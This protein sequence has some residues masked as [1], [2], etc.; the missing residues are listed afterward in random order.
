MRED[1]NALKIIGIVADVITISGITILTV[2]SS[3]RKNKDL[4]G[5][6]INLYLT[7]FIR[8]VLIVVFVGIILLYIQKPYNFFL[9]V[10]KGYANG[11]LWEK[12]KEIQH[13]IAYFITTVLVLSVLW[14]LS[15]IVWTSSFKYAFDFF[16]LLLPGRPFKYKLKIK[17]K[18]DILS[19][20]YGSDTNT[21]DITEVLRQMVNDEK[22]RIIANNE[23]GGDPHPNVKK[24]L[25]VTYKKGAYPKTVEVIE[26]E[27]LEIGNE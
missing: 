2:M 11:E 3:I 25:K 27:I 23:L 7:Y 24:K 8:S 14:T 26:D 10:F 17:S 22:L 6:K 12:G 1:L 5:F 16:N 18:L 15:T 13:I 19:A 20:I 4:I 21:I 9:T